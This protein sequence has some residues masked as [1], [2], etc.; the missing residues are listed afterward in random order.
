MGLNTSLDSLRAPIVRRVERLQAQWAAFAEDEDARLL[1]WVLAPD[2]RKL[3]DT[4]F[5]VE[6]HDGGVS[7][8]L[9]LR[10]EVPFAA[11][12]H[13]GLELVEAMAS[14][15]HAI[16]HDLAQAG[17]DASWVPPRRE[18]G[19]D[20][21]RVFLQAAQSFHEHHQPLF[22]HLVLVLLSEEVSSSA[23]WTAWVERTVLQAH[24]AQVRLVCFDDPASPTL[25]EV[26]RAQA[27]RVRTCVAGLDMGAAMEEVSSAAGHLDTPQG[28]FR[29]L[30]VKLGRALE[31]RD[32]GAARSLATEAVAVAKAQE[33]SHLVVATH[34]A[35]ATGCMT[36]EDFPAAVACYRSAEAEALAA[37]QRGEAQGLPLQLK[38]RMAL[39]GA[40][41]CARTYS[42]SGD[43]YRDTAPLAEQLKDDRMLLECWRMAAYGYELARDHDASWACGVRAFPVAHRMDE[44]TRRTST[45]G[46][47]GD[48]LMRL[49]RTWKY[50]AHRSVVEEQMSRLLGPAWRPPDSRRPSS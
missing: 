18:P 41:I 3:M 24:A 26:A 40:L 46:Y 37:H 39:G 43:L 2:E 22:R 15:Y 21:S 16:R 17:V 48:G 30:Y 20:D 50:R 19:Q 23:D 25:A 8:D 10:L 13:H 42:R 11:P 7:P 49:T 28:H 45:L 6:E 5:V 38:V 33:W 12:S 29:H 14:Q 36:K 44:E 4:F 1:R 27:R 9:F 35:L 34:V 47:L 31:A 32:L